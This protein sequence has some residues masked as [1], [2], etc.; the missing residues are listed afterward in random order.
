M[1]NVDTSTAVAQDVVQS[2][3][4]SAGEAPQ[5][6]IWILRDSWTEAGRHLRIVPRAI[7]VLIFA[8]IQPVMFVLLFSYV[9]GGS[10]GV[11]GFDDY[12]QYL[13]PGIFAQTVLFGSGFTGIGI[14]EDMTKGLIQRL[15]SL[16]MS[17]PA[18]IIGRT[19]SDLVRNIL[20]FIVM[21][22]VGFLVGFRF[23][24]GWLPAL[25]ACALLLGFA[26]A[27]SWVQALFGLS[28]GSVETMNSAG[29]LW[30]F[31]LTFVSSAFVDPSTMPGPL[32]WFADV[33][34]FTI[35]TNASRALFN[36]Y[37]AGNDIWV[38]VFWMIGITVVFGALSIM[39]FTRANRR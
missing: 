15:R 4:V 33:N 20:S 32:H 38:S 23:E 29:F 5:G 21:I 9:F 2:S 26:Y 39:R 37:D 1:S 16:P 18:V 31:P 12:D 11:E 27:F 14:A 28:V 30:M 24:G 8:T 7:D 22:L 35:A 10:I 6:P 19:I 17:Q 25:G 3:S 13:L 36:G 34:P